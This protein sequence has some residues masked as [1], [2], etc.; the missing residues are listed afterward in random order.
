VTRRSSSSRW[1]QRQARDPYVRRAHQ[2]GRR[3]RAV[4]KLEE[5]QAR[6]RLLHAGD[7]V[8]DLGAA[9]GG[10]SEYARTLV[11]PKGRVLA[12]DLLPLDPIEGVD[13]ICGD[14]LDE[15][16]L[17]EIETRL[18]GSPVDLVLSDMAPNLSG[19]WSVDHPRSMALAETAV[20]FAMR[21]LKPGGSLAVK[22]FQGE[23]T[24]ALVALVRKHFSPVKWRKPPA[25]RAESREIYLVARNYRI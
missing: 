6:D 12:V 16:T 4:F 20:D 7:V 5:I 10:W 24:D 2:E 1:K 11:G 3:S 22:L 21:I 14:F 18:A 17:V 13:Y 19:N 23:G 8:V 9:P 15:K 25:S